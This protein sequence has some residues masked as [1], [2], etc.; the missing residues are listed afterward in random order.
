MGAD[1]EATDNQGRT[2]LHTSASRYWADAVEFLLEEGANIDAKDNLGHTPIYLAWT[3]RK[4]VIDTGLGIYDEFNYSECMS[5][6]ATL[7]HRVKDLDKTI[8][9]LTNVSAKAFGVQ[10]AGE[11]RHS[12]S[13]SVIPVHSA[14]SRPVR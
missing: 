9:L 12:M 13:G 4:D 5:A 11:K 10:G 2:P 7:K 1:L 8:G 14:T 6:E 3:T